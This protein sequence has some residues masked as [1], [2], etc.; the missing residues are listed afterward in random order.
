MQPMLGLFNCK[1]ETFTWNICQELS[2]DELTRVLVPLI[3]E[4]VKRHIESLAL[5]ISHKLEPGR[6]QRTLKLAPANQTDND[7][8]CL[9][10]NTGDQTLSQEPGRAARVRAGAEELQEEFQQTLNTW[11]LETTK[12]GSD[13]H[14]ENFLSM[15]FKKTTLQDYFIGEFFICFT[16]L[17]I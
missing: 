16:N 13:N 15:G 1:T 12:L 6:G 11:G 8:C 10:T 14:Q 4:S 3:E 9:H 5:R 17:N 2:V 7:S